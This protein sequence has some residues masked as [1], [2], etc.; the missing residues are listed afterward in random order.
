MY[1]NEV[2]T[3]AESQY[4][5]VYDELRDKVFALLVDIAD[6]YLSLMEEAASEDPAPFLARTTPM[7]ATMNGLVENLEMKRKGQLPQYRD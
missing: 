7:Q 3:L 6:R 1:Y 2:D 4:G 5:S